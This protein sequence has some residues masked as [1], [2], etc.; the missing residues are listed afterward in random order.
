M[1]NCVKFY[2]ISDIN[3]NDAINLGIL[4]AEIC[5]HLNVPQSKDS[6]GAGFDWFNTIGWNIAVKGYKLDSIEMRNNIESYEC[7]PL[8]KILDYMIVNYTAYGYA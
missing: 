7:N 8:I 2:K 6:W 4:D 1:P 3:Q 5:K